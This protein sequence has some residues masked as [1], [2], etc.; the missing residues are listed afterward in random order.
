MHQG[1]RPSLD[2]RSDIS[3]SKYL[4]TTSASI[5]ILFK[6]H[7]EI[8]VSKNLFQKKYTTLLVSACLSGLSLTA[9]ALPQGKPFQELSSAVTANTVSI[10]ANSEEIAAIQDNIILINTQIAAIDLTLSALDVR[11]ADNTAG[12]DAALIR[13]STNEGDLDLL[14][15]E[16]GLLRGELEDEIDS[17]RIE[18]N[19]R[20]DDEIAAMVAANE[21]L[22]A[23]LAQAV[24]DLSNAISLGDAAVTDALTTQ[25]TLLSAQVTTNTARI[26]SVESWKTSVVTQIDTN[27]SQIATLDAELAALKQAVS[28]YHDAC[29]ESVSIGQSVTGEMVND[30]E[31]TSDSR[32][33]TPALS[34]RYYTFDV[35]A[36]QAVTIAMNGTGGYFDGA[37]TDEGTLYD[38][39]LYLHAG[40]RDG[41]VM[42][43]NDDAG[44]GYNSRITRTLAPGTYTIEA[45]VFGAGSNNGTFTLHIN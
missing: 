11:I 20:L 40:G 33:R 38:P 28:T 12:I 3:F 15:G 8:F 36:S 23:N 42:T 37:C 1:W 4:E 19:S 27:S 5:I 17:L 44:C 45:T 6:H 24:L 30:G 31:C 21:A 26:S 29:L 14:Q 2:Q 13:I 16:I 18:L 9:N 25:V 22:A 34:A 41:A 43:D 39:Y 35:L 7:M 32:V 10:E